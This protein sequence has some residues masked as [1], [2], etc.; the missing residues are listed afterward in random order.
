MSIAMEERPQP[1][2]MTAATVEEVAA[3]LSFAEGREVTIHEV[4]RIEA[5]ALRKLRHLLQ[6]RGLAPADLLP[7]RE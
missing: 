6:G 7:G 1:V 5:Q 2:E 3:Q 4:R